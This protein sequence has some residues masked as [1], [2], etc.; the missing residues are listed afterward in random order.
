MY[1]RVCQGDC[2]G[3]NYIWFLENI[4]FVVCPI[5][6]CN[7]DNGF[8]VWVSLLCNCGPLDDLWDEVDVDMW[9]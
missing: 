6:V 5:I 3:G 1:W 9:M 7:D 4:N 8:V 2:Y